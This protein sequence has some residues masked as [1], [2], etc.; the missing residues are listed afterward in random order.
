MQIHKNKV[1]YSLR[2]NITISIGN[3]VS[4]SQLV[5]K[6][7]SALHD[8]NGDKVLFVFLDQ[9]QTPI[10]PHEYSKHGVYY[11]VTCG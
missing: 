11:T 2:L 3:T 6:F 8:D 7:L 9:F 5:F 1:I 10:I 4:Q